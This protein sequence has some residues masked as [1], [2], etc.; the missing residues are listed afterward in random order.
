MRAKIHRCPLL[1]ESGH[2]RV[3]LDC[4]LSAI[5]GLMHRSK[6]HP[7]SIIS[8]ALASILQL[9]KRRDREHCHYSSPIRKIYLAFFHSLT[10]VIAPAGVITSDAVN[11]IMSPVKLTFCVRIVPSNNGDEP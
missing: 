1:S 7:Y 11:T 8:V 10:G 4:P 2:S 3:C 5:S 9:G 6:Q